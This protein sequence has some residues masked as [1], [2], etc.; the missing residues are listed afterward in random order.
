MIDNA[1]LLQHMMPPRTTTHHLQGRSVPPRR[2][3]TH[4]APRPA[5]R[6]TNPPGPQEATG[7]QPIWETTPPGHCSITGWTET[8]QTPTIC[9]DAASAAATTR[10]CG[11]DC[12]CTARSPISYAGEAGE[13]ARRKTDAV[14]CGLSCIISPASWE[15]HNRSTLSAVMDLLCSG[16]N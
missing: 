13:T 11:L 3:L 4:F 1:S 7:R 5:F 15:F 10:R 16:A 8:R 6:L 14:H 2:Q 12:G 9:G